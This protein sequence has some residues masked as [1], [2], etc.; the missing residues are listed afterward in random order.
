MNMEQNRNARRMFGVKPK[1]AEWCHDPH[2]FEKCT[3]TW[4]QDLRKFLT[5]SWHFV[6]DES[7][8]N[9]RKEG[10]LLFGDLYIYICIRVYVYMC[11]CVC[12]CLCMVD[13]VVECCVMA[14]IVKTNRNDDDGGVATSSW[15]K[16]K[17]WNMVNISD[18]K[19]FMIFNGIFQAIAIIFRC[20]IT[21]AFERMKEY[22]EG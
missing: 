12:V 11:I 21:Q 13:T 8:P 18:A 5:E 4:N 10:K 7:L 17:K 14:E 19:I 1:E 15:I 22:L 20:K 6:W 16:R 2:W 9:P 3:F